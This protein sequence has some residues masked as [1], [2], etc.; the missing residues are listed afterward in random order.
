MD[1]YKTEKLNNLAREQNSTLYMVLLSC[2]Y[3]LLSRYS[4]QNTITVGTAV[5]GRT[6]KEVE[7][8][9][10]MFVNTLALKNQI[11]EELTF[12]EFLKEI[13]TNVLLALENQEY[14][15]EEM[16]KELNVERQFNRNP[17]FDVMFVLQNMDNIEHNIGEITIKEIEWAPPVEKMD[18]TV[19]VREV[20]GQLE[21][22]FSFAV[23]LF[24]KTT[25]EAMTQ[26]YQNIIDI[27]LE[28]TLIRLNDIDILNEEDKV[29]LL[30]ELNDHWSQYP[31]EASVIELFEEQVQK[32]PKQTAVT[33]S[34]GSM[35]Y[36]ELNWQANLLA[37]KLLDKGIEKE[38]V[39]GIM[40]ERTC[41]MIVGILGI[42]KAGRHTYQ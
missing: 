30:V 14:P 32:S 26:H 40:T 9:I 6:R 16:V 20:E 27:I 38:Q 10:G 8:I 29:E 4:G 28:N 33:D 23:L 3:I 18:L 24:D 22:I 2:F 15:F 37:N 31:R 13:K 25:I 5:A 39:V 7:N 12:N 17:V 1:K 36:E 34:K 21:F 41:Q 11:K 35:N 42:L 19:N